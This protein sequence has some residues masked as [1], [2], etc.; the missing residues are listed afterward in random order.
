MPGKVKHLSVEN[1]HLSLAVSDGELNSS[2]PRGSSRSV[3]SLPG[4]QNAGCTARLPVA[5]WAESFE[6][7]LQDRVAI[8]YFTEF[9][10]KEFSAENVYFWQACERF[11]QIS[12]TDTQQLAQEAR[13]IYDNFLS[14]HSVS[15]VNI[16]RQAWVG[17]EMLAVPTPD[18]FRAQQLQIFNLMK[19]DSYARFVRSPLYQACL[20][21]EKE[22]Q[23]LP[24]WPAHAQH[25]SP[26]PDPGQKAKLKPGKSLPLGVE[27]AGSCAGR[28]PQRSFRR[29]K[30]REP[31]WTELGDSSEGLSLWRESQG[32]LNSSASLDLG[33]LLASCGGSGSSQLDVS[34]QLPEPLPGCTASSPHGHR[35]SLGGTEPEPQARPSKYCCVYLPDGT[36]SLASVRAG[37][38]IRDMLAGLCEKRGFS[39]PDIKVYLVGKEQKALVLDQDSVVLMDQEVK[40]ENRVSFELEISPLS[41][42][43]R[44]TAKSTKC[45][46]E[47]L[48]PVLGKY[49]VDVEQALLRRQGDAG[50]VDLE[51]LVGTV[52][53]QRLILEAA[54][55]GK[56]TG[57]CD[58][59]QAPCP[60]QCKDPPLEA[61]APASFARP[62]PPPP[63][64]ANRHT[65][66]LEGLVELLNRAQSCQANDQRGLLSKEVLVL[67]D[68]LQLPRQDACPSEG[69]EQQPGS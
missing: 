10:K 59:A 69:C 11:H 21:A 38:S 43:V 64:S 41:K 12:A 23:P 56:A 58:T 36:A 39:L 20:S 29:A 51:K 24:A 48:Q 8:A 18:M 62:R 19:F 32:S 45:L 3:N 55:E 26:P 2:G 34:A 61:E 30:Q 33:F 15:P 54:T 14:S 40:L 66:D 53:A 17:E 6:M 16:D 28:S 50:A 9:L 44:I 52:A 7:L 49:G 47:A 67:P 46:R 1:S 63:Q 22:G 5:R 25:R 31:S 35:R 4:A 42:T 65:Y 60:P 68:F 57:A 13:R 27:V 37:L